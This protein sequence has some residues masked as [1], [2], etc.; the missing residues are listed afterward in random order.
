[1]Y[2]VDFAIKIQ[3][4]SLYAQSLYFSIKHWPIIFTIF[5]NIFENSLLSAAFSSNLLEAIQ[6]LYH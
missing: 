4:F 6:F 5:S 3:F 2:I 1:M